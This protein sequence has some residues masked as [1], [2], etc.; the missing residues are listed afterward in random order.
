MVSRL[1][2]RRDGDFVLVLARL[3]GS[4]DCEVAVVLWCNEDVFDT[5]GVVGSM[6]A[7]PFADLDFLGSVDS[8]CFTQGR[9]PDNHE[10][11]DGGGEQRAPGY[12]SAV[13]RTEFSRKHIC[14]CDPPDC[15]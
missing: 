3:R 2:R 10:S 1:D 11:A 7:K 15:P 13:G 9:E 5:A 4:Q 6:L 12:Q 8:V 14:C